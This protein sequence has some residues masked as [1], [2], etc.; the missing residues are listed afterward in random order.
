MSMKY[1]LFYTLKAK[2]DLAGIDPKIAKKILD[3]IDFYIETAE[4]IKHAKKLKD[5]KFGTYRFKIGD[6]RA[7]FDVDHKGNISILIILR[8]KHRREVYL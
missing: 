8:I 6:Y 1:K 4:P 7:I 2:K 3:K 5:F